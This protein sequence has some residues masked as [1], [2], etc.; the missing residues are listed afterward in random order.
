MEITDDP[1]GTKPKPSKKQIKDSYLL[2]TDDIDGAQGGSRTEHLTALPNSKRTEF[3]NTNYLG[4]II[5]AQADSIKHSIRTTRVTNPLQP[6]YQALDYGDVICGPIDPL[7]PVDLIDVR[8]NFKVAG[9]TTKSHA[10]DSTFSLSNS[11]TAN[12]LSS[13]AD[14]LKFD[15]TIPQDA[16]SRKPPSGR[17]G[18]PLALD[19]SSSMPSGNQYNKA[20]G[21]SDRSS[22]GSQLPSSRLNQNSA[23]SIPSHNNSARSARSTLSHTEKRA[24]QE[25][26]N[27]I[28]AVRSL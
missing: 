3:R 27:E 10:Q 22:N 26:A 1:L 2:R 28:S 8:K 4:D 5:G 15:F 25:I 16:M 24:M 19:L 17:G 7:V 20:S 14:T 6:V 9:G 12:H 11:M 21:R 18:N 13:S 23:R